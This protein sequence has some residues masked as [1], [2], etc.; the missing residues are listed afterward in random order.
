M[1]KIARTFLV[2]LIAFSTLLV[3]QLFADDNDNACIIMAPDQNDVWVIIY[4]TDGDGNRG[5]VI[6]QGKLAAGQ[7]KEI[8]SS[9]GSIHYDFTLNPKDAYEGDVS[10]GCFQNNTI[11]IE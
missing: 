7:K 9:A 6:W 11:L 4:D 3:P 10:E 8:V 1:R 2:I 5:K